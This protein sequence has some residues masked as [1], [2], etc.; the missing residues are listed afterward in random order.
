M[1][2][3]G[4]RVPVSEL[5]HCSQWGASEGL[6]RILTLSLVAH[7]QEGAMEIL[8]NAQQQLTCL[9]LTS[10]TVQSSEVYMCTRVRA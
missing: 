6:D 9:H 2:G 10:V 4:S 8:T 5:L 1:R 7:Y 3:V